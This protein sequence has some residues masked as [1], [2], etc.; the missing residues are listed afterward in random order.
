VARRE[1]ES[2]LRV[3]DRR[4]AGE[5]ALEIEKRGR[6]GKAE[7]RPREPDADGPAVGPLDLE[8]ADAARTLATRALAGEEGEGPIWRKEQEAR[9]GR[10]HRDQGA[11][12]TAA[13]L[14]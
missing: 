14:E 5:P 1:V 12:V 10:I 3:L 13:K 9:P 2:N 7:H 4:G 11:R 8:T 6:V